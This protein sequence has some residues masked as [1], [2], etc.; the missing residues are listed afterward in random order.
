MPILNKKQIF[1]II[2]TLEITNFYEAIVKF[3]KILLTALICSNIQAPVMQFDHKDTCGFCIFVSAPVAV[4][5][6]GTAAVSAKI[7]KKC[8]NHQSKSGISNFFN[9]YIFGPVASTMF[10]CSSVVGAVMLP[11]TT[12]SAGYW[13]Y[14]HIIG[15][16]NL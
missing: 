13:G 7:M 3:Q 8:F 14:L 4:A 6:I 1:A 5:S 15:K 11:I 12:L 10:T 9:S 2:K 16:R